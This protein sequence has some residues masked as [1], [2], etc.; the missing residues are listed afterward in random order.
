MGVFPLVGCSGGI[1]IIWDPYVLE[2]VDSRMGS[3]SMCCRFKSLQDD[4]AWGL[5]GICGTN[6]DNVRCALFEELVTSM[7]TWDMSL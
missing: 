5:F 1:I 2:L 7:S 3:F 6:D 4:F